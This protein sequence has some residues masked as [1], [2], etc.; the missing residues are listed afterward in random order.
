MIGD[1][2]MPGYNPSKAAL[3]M[4][5]VRVARELRETPIKEN[6][7]HPGWVKTDMGTD[8][9]PMEIIDGAKDPR[10]PRDARTRRA[11]RWLLSSGAAAAVVS[12]SHLP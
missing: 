6:A 8:A 2:V 3:N 7:A 5:T 1:H 9:A 11:E 12:S 4:Y 10:S